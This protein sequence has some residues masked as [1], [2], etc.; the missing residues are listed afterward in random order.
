MGAKEDIA[1][2]T[3]IFRPHFHRATERHYLTHNRESGSVWDCLTPLT[4]ASSFCLRR[5]LFLQVIVSM[6]DRW[7]SGVPGS[8][9]LR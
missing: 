3:L 4:A 8:D 6:F 5:Y 1:L 2:G 7:G 9:G